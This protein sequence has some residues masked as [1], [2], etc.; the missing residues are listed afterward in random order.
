AA[1]RRRAGAWQPHDADG[2]RGADLAAGRR[3]GGDHRT[4]MGNRAGRRGRGDAGLRAVGETV[5]GAA[6]YTRG[7]AV[8]HRALD[9]VFHG[10]AD[11]GALHPAV[12]EHGDVRSVLPRGAQLH[13][14]LDLGGD[15]RRGAVDLPGDAAGRAGGGA[16]GVRLPHGATGRTG[17]LRCRRHGGAGGAAYRRVAAADADAS[18]TATA[19]ALGAP[20]RLAFR[21]V[22]PQVAGGRIPSSGAPCMATLDKAP[23]ISPEF[24]AGLFHFTVFAAT[25]VASAYFGIW[26]INRGITADEIGLINAAPVLAMLA[27]NVLVGRLADKA[28]DW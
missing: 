19:D 9:R 6:P 3:A 7:R 21:Q 26:L 1:A 18:R 4:A 28:S 2:L 16:D 24:R 27:I 14:Q 15:C 10:A 5:L 23:G 13:R 25:G 11:L 8:Q 20:R 17:L 22:R 12:P